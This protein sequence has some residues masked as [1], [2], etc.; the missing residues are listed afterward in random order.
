MTDDKPLPP[1][2][3]RRGL[4][5]E[6][7]VVREPTPQARHWPSAARAQVED[8]ALAGGSQRLGEL[9][10]HRVVQVGELDGHPEQIGDRV[11]E[12][13]REPRQVLELEQLPPPHHG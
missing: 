10:E 13:R 12:D 1:A 6:V 5:R 9:R 7:M 4:D 2:P 11:T 3:V 8:G